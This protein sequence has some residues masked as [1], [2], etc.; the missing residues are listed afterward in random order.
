MSRPSS[1][2]EKATVVEGQASRKPSQTGLNEKVEVLTTSASKDKKETKDVD[3]L[4]GPAPVSFFKLFRFHTG[5]ELFLNILGLFAAAAA[6]AAQPMMSLLF[7][8][9][10]GQFVAFTMT[11]MAAEAGDEAAKAALPGAAAS[12]RHVAAQDASYLVYIGIGMFVC[13]YLYM[14]VWVYTGEVGAKR[15]REKYL[16]AVLRQDIA[17][18][19]KVGAGEV[20]TRIQTDTHLMQQATSEKVALTISFLAA[21]ITG[22]VLAY[23]R[24]WRLALA[25]T[26]ILP[27]MAIAGGFMNKFISMYKQFSLQHVAEGGNMAEEVIST[28]R[29]AQA[30]GTQ[31]T[32][33]ALY[34]V[35]INKSLAVELK[36]SIWNGAGLAFFFFVIYASYGLAFHWGTTLIIKGYADAGQVV[37]VILAILIGSISLTML[38]P[39]IQ[40]LSHGCSAA[41][42]LYE[43]IDRR[44]DIDSSDPGGLK[45][46]KVEGEIKLEG[47]RFAYPSRPTLEVTK[48]LDLTFRA[49]KTAA[50]VGA[51]GSGKSTVIQLVERFYDPTAGVVKFDGLNIK[52]LNLKWLRS[53][54]GLVSQEPTLFATTIKNNVAHGLINTPFEHASEEEKFALIKEACV[55]ANADGFISKLPNGYDTMVGERGFLLSG[56]QK[57]RIAIARAIVSDPKVLLLDEATS[58]L[59][60]QSE[61]I[62]QDALDKASA[63]RTTITIAHRLSTIKGADVIYVMGDGLVLEQGTHN[64]LLAKQGSYAALVQAQKLREG[65]KPKVDAEDSDDDDDEKDIEAQARDEVPLGRRNTGRSLASE[66]IEQKRL[67]AGEEKE[68]GDL[69]IFTLFK[70]MAVLVPDQW[71]NYA[72]AGFFAC[73]T[74]MVFPAFGVVYAKGIQGFSLETDAEK[75]HAGDRNALWFFI[76]AILST[77]AVGLQN[78][79]FAAAATELTARLRSLSFRAVLRQDIAFFDKDENSS[80]GLTSNL[81]ENPQKVNG[82]AGITLGAIVQSFATV[83]AGTILGLVFIWRVALVALACTPLLVSTGYIRLQVVVLKDQANKKAH[84]ESAQLACEAAGSIRTVASLTREDDCLEIYSRSLDLPLKKSNRNAI[85]SN[86][87]YALSQSFTM[88]VIAL[89]FWYGSRLVSTFQA[90]TFQ[91]F[92]GLMSTTFGAVQAGNVFSFVPDVSTAKGAGSDIIRLLDSVPEIDAESEEGKKIDPSEVQGHLKLDNIHFRYPTR[93]GVRVLREL[94]IEVQPGTYVALVGASGSGKSTVIQLLERFYDPLAGEIYLDGHNI[95]ELHVQEYRKH[96]ALVSQE[97]TLYAGTVRF[98]ILLGAIKPES[99]VTQEE[100]EDAC[101]N[102][103]ILDFIKSL[104]NGFD[105]EVGGKGSQ[106][107]GGQKQRIAIARALLRN[108][109]VLL[110]DEAT[111]A[112]DSHSEKVVQA[113]LDQAAKG[114][115]TIAIAHRLSTIQ[116]ADKIYF[117]KEGKVSEFGTHDQLLA[118]KGDYYEYVQ[119]QALSKNE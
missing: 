44:P 80:G 25:M 119:L 4:T 66:I 106:L 77:I 1:A 84:E 48:G 104:P 111:S 15:T 19:D 33:A 94:S 100:L 35:H 27:C 31:K 30:F 114:R 37:N 2:D 101:R 36:S 58:A 72:F 70:R 32:L 9:L 41:A 8:N 81:S 92:V 89:V 16:Q 59:D 57:Q 76:I 21:F 87:L 117:I 86:A 34:D 118:K 14:F 82:L 112:L 22:F 113:A 85:W 38:A 69:S 47:V 105:T 99:E 110:L 54:V 98:N 74:G 97:P 12:F 102:A 20:A 50:L 11:T 23:V 62:V 26:S 68:A 49:G 79:Y 63:G 5:F 107:S 39:E 28:V 51:S 10:T 65:E 116:N 109:K 53:Q 55:K 103:N 13:T 88:F 64:D 93:A 17:Y 73:I 42:K 90:T 40:A 60:T 24:Q 29:T 83:V 61:G 43:T 46:E 6:G 95:S 96:L 91:F 52:E 7:G 67:A 71:R 78:Y 45:P 75:R 115:T 3:V 108:P 18:F 56:G